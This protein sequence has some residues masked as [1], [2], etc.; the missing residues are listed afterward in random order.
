[1]KCFSAR[2]DYIEEKIKLSFS[3]YPHI[4]VGEEGRGRQYTRFPV[5]QQFATILTPPCPNWG[6]E[7]DYTKS[8]WGDN[9]SFCPVCGAEVT[10]VPD[11]S[12]CK[13]LHP[14]T[15]WDTGS[16]FI[17]RAS[18][19]KTRA[20]GTLLMVDEKNPDD[21]RAIVLVDI[22]AGFRGVTSWTAAEYDEIPCKYQGQKDI[23]MSGFAANAQRCECCGETVTY[24]NDC[25]SHPASGYVKAWRDFSE[26]S[27][28]T[29]LAEGYCAQ[30]TAGRMG[31][32]TVKLLIMEPGSI[33]RIVRGGRLYGH[34]S[35]RY[36]RWTGETLQLG[37]YDEI[38]PPSEIVE[39]GEAI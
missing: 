23:F 11:S 38:F 6:K 16:V 35:R 13:W 31:G 39:E 2:S 7:I 8:S 3:P 24:E 5:A 32:H 33:F 20:K 37:T 19:I 14:N 30:G 9:K 27:G 17:S 4:G 25:W 15:G 10:Q 34:P 21:N 28:I 18:I 22:A 36:V 12:P 1:M 29:V 26:V